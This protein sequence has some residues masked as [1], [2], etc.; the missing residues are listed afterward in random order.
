MLRSSGLLRLEVSRVMIFQFGLKTGGCAARMVHMA[1]SWRSHRDR[2]EDG[3]V[4]ATGY[5]ELFYP[6][7]IVLIVLVPKDNLV[8]WLGL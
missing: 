2:A 7:F 4:N 1:S 5:I 3:R 6:N 8:F